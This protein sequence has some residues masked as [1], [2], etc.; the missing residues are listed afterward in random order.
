MAVPSQTEVIKDSSMLL[1]KSMIAENYDALTST[2]ETG[3][4]ISSTF[5]PGNLNEL[6]MCFDMLN[7]LPEIN[8]INNGMRKKS[9]RKTG[10]LRRC[11]HLCEGRYRFDV[12]GQY[13]TERQTHAGTRP[14]A[15]VIHRLFHFHEVVRVAAP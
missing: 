14:V 3:K 9:G 4:K 8:A 2:A 1:Q 15:V 10:A 6:I 11:L 13:C 7:N 12:Q 5:V